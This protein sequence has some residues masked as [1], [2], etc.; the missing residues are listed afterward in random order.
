MSWW[1]GCLYGHRWNGRRQCV[2]LFWE[3]VR[4]HCFGLWGPLLWIGLCGF[5]SRRCRAR[6]SGITC[7]VFGCCLNAFR[8]V[9]RSRRN[10]I[11]RTALRP[12]GSRRRGMPTALAHGR[13]FGIRR[14]D[15]VGFRGGFK[16]C[17]DGSFIG[18]NTQSIGCIHG[19]PRAGSTNPKSQHNAEASTRTCNRSDH[20]R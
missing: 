4:R 10:R 15:A 9:E 1:Y 20:D 2:A 6:E 5:R 11:A 7:G 12:F 13:I 16:R 8:S 19:G 17:L 14:R 3:R 18:H